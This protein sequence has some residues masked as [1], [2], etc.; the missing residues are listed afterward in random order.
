MKTR[1]ILGF[2]LITALIVTMCIMS[3]SAANVWSSTGKTAA[4][5]G[6]T[7]EG[8]TTPAASNTVTLTGTAEKTGL[9]IVALAYSYTK[10][11]DGA[12]QGAATGTGDK[13]AV[14]AGDEPAATAATGKYKN[15]VSFSFTA[16]SDIKASTDVTFTVQNTFVDYSNL[17]AAILKAEAALVG[18]TDGTGAKE[19][20]DVFKY[21]KYVTTADKTTFTDAIDLA[22][23]QV[24]YTSTV[25]LDNATQV[26]AAVTAL[27]TAMTTFNGKVINGTKPNGNIIVGV[28]NSTI[29]PDTAGYTTALN[30]STE[31]IIGALT[32]ADVKSFSID[33]G[34][35]WKAVGTKDFVKDI[36]PK[37]LNKSITLV[38][39]NKELDKESK[40]DGVKN[41]N[42]GK[43]ELG[44][45]MVAFPKTEART[46]FGGNK[47]YMV[48]Y[49]A[50]AKAS[51]VDT[52][53]LTEAKKDDLVNAFTANVLVSVIEKEDKKARKFEAFPDA[54]GRAI[55]TIGDD[56]KV[57][58]MAY[59]MKEDAKIDGGKYIPSTKEQK[60]NVVGFGKAPKF[61]FDDK[62]GLVKI[63]AGKTELVAI[64][65]A[66]SLFDST[67]N[68]FETKDGKDMIKATVKELIV[69][70]TGTVQF[71]TAAT[72]KKPASMPCEALTIAPKPAEEE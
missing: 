4:A 51:E 36:L 70:G 67:K 21:T 66:K 10:D 14:K 63:K 32:G 59:A 35:K 40:I 38:V 23:T 43:P 11:D 34:A 19:A 58:K 33:N 48:N 45:T 8:P 17:E 22:K 2:L 46:K 9:H 20:K 55:Q 25:K 15:S 68:Y 65:T 42:K 41:N 47:K 6:I 5:N 3:V 16:P 18:V 24:A 30:L 69:T 50:S 1:K 37:L 27:N 29:D 71:R 12:G 72:S 56:G 49:I 28:S 57:V 62:K 54:T 61:K 64:A 13:F 31:N 44:A 53:T 7:A 60:L 39:A 26:T 52:W